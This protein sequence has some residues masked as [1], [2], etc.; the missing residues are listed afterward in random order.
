M[1]FTN[2]LIV[3]LHPLSQLIDDRVEKAVEQR[4]NQ[5]VQELTTVSNNYI[6]SFLYFIFL[7]FVTWQI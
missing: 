3:I 7:F 5:A 6:V 4:V 2:I 1:N